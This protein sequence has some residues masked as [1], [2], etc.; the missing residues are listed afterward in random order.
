MGLTELTELIV[1]LGDWTWWI[2]A[3]VLFVLELLA[4]GVFFLWFGVAAMLTGV[5]V[6]VVD[7]SWQVQIAVFSVLSVV[8]LVAGRRYFASLW[9]RTDQPNLNRRMNNFVGRSFQLDQPIHGRRGQIEID[10]ALWKIEGP[11]CEAGTWVTVRSVNGLSL[12][13]EPDDAASGEPA[14]T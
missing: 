13:V 8:S 9:N 10:D 3:G 6:L 2:V 1:S 14:K 7:V 4:P 11:D 5:M 12:V